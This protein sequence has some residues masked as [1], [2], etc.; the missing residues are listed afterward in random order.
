MI[1]TARNY[2]SVEDIKRTI[3]GLMFNKMNTLHWHVVDSQSFPFVSRSFP[4]LSLFGAYE[5]WMI[6]SPGDVE[7][8]VNYATLAGVRVISIYCKSV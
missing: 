6:Y 5:P 3:D 1:D 2:L 8:I 4:E 7:E